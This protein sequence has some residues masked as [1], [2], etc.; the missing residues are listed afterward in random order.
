MRFRNY[1]LI[2]TV[3]VCCLCHLPC[4][5]DDTKLT[6][7]LKAT[8]ELTDKIIKWSIAGKIDEIW[9]VCSERKIKELVKTH[10]DESKAKDFLKN[11]YSKMKAHHWKIVKDNY[12]KLN[13]SLMITLQ[14]FETENDKSTQVKQ[15]CF[16]RESGTWKWIY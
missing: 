2:V 3:L 14:L 13:D 8:R 9:S 7:D 11:Q 12:E 10:G 16:V 6:E 15:F 1:C 4:F 5:A